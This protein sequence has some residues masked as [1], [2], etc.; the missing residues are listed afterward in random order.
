MVQ[1]QELHPLGPGDAP[2]T[3]R[4]ALSI[5]VTRQLA[6]VL[7]TLEGPL[8]EGACPVLASVLSDL[9]VGQG[10][11]SVTVDARDLVVSDPLLTAVFTT[12]AL[13]AEH[14]G[15]TFAV[16]EPASPPASR[17]GHPPGTPLRFSRNPR[18][19]RRA[20]AEHP[21]GSARRTHRSTRGAQDDP[22]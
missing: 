11:L 21:A 13:E 7:V 9:V 17:A 12:L 14:R 22:M 4:P 18:S 5:A 8:E 1:H 20:M 19:A 2:P 10:N 3:R 6:T 15:G 16:V